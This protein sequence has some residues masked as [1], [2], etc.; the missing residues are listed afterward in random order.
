[1]KNVIILEPSSSVHKLECK[2][3]PITV[4]LDASSLFVTTNGESIV[5]HGHHGTLAVESKTFLKV[6]QQELNPVTAEL[7]NAFD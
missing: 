5:T 1:M 4:R 6:V 3:T 2:A 7:Q